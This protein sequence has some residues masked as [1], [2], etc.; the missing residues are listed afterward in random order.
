MH[1]LQAAERPTFVQEIMDV[2]EAFEQGGARI[3]RG[4][5]SVS[6]SAAYGKLKQEL[7]DAPSPVLRA[8]AKGSA[9]IILAEK[10]AAQVSQNPQVLPWVHWFLFGLTVLTTT[11]AGA[12]DQGVDLFREPRRF[13]VGLPYSLGLLTILGIHELGHYFAARRHRVQVTPPYFLPVPVSVGTFGALIQMRSPAKD[14]KA[15]FDVAV[16]GPL[17]GLAIAIPALLIGLHSSLIAVGNIPAPLEN[18]IGT[19]VGSS[20]L[21]ALAAKLSLGLALQYGH[22]LRLGPLAFAGWIGLL[23][24]GLNLLPIGQLDGGHIARAMFGSKGAAAVSSISML[25][26]FLL[27]L[28]VWPGLMIWAIIVFF[29]ARTGSSPLN[30]LSPLSAGRRALGYLAFAILALILVPL[31]HSLWHLAGIHC[32]YA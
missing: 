10:S 4:R 25:A 26:L 28:F 6:P 7:G 11:W 19:S 8:D 23:V 17:A 14:R 1:D 18:L 30:D 9:T 5:L 31:P 20:L 27:A 22:V 16:A 21:L 15:L 24:T 29:L 32:P 13:A 12:A 3:F 2:R